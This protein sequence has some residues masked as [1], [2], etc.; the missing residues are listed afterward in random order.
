MAYYNGERRT[1]DMGEASDEAT[2]DI[3]LWKEL[4]AIILGDIGG[5]QRHGVPLRCDYTTLHWRFA[6]YI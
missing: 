4:K 3:S 2:S 5:I 6:R 1:Y